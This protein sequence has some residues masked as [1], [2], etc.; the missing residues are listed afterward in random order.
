MED[1][2]HYA[3]RIKSFC[4]TKLKIH[5]KMYEQWGP[6]YAERLRVVNEEIDRRNSGE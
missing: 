3:R 1:L 5:R 4:V 2:E 6:K